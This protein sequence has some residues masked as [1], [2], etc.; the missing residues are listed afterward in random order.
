MV[1]ITRNN[2][3]IRQL[4]TNERQGFLKHLLGLDKQ[5]RFL[6]FGSVVSDQWIEDYVAHSFE[7]NCY[8]LG[9]F[10]S[11]GVLRGSAELRFSTEQI[12]L[13]EAAFTVDPICQGLGIGSLL[14]ERLLLEAHARELAHVSVYCLLENKPMMKIAKKFGGNF[15]FE[16]GMAHY[17][18]Q[19]SQ[20]IGLVG[21]RDAG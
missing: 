21:M 13:S 17:D 4:T 1:Q 5:C 14:M 2:G 20:V 6:R 16:C 8:L 15:A 7:G 3:H 18:I 11:F 9:Y 10:D 19:P 12:G